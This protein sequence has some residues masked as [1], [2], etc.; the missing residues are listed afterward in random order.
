[1]GIGFVL[2]WIVTH[3]YA[4]RSSHELALLRQDL[5]EA[6]KSGEIELKRNSKGRITGATVLRLDTVQIHPPGVATQVTTGP[7]GPSAG[8]T[9]TIK[10]TEP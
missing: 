10:T 3:L 1:L 2:G 6:E 9:L 4:R 8:S 7:L 5:L